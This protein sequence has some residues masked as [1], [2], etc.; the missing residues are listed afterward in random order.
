MCPARE[1]DGDARDA[2]DPGREPA[3]RDV[4]ADAGGTTGGFSRRDFEVIDTRRVERADLVRDVLRR[5]RDA[6]RAGADE[7]GEVRDAGVESSGG[8]ARGDAVTSAAGGAAAG[9]DDTIALARDAKGRVEA[10]SAVVASQPERDSAGDAP[11][12]PA[13]RRGAV[14]VTLTDAVPT[15][16]DTVRLSRD[17][18]MRNRSDRLEPGAPRTRLQQTPPAAAG[19]PGAPSSGGPGPHRRRPPRPNATPSD[20][21]GAALAMLRGWRAEAESRAATVAEAQLKARTERGRDRLDPTSELRRAVEGEGGREFLRDLLDNVIRPDDRIVA[22]NGLGDLA[23]RIPTTISVQARRAFRVGVFAGPGVPWLAVPALRRTARAFFGA[24]VVSDSSEERGGSA[25][26]AHE[27][28][29]TPRATP[30]GDPIVGRARAAE[31]LRRLGELV[32]DPAFPE[33]EFTM[34]DLEPNPNLWNLDGEVER[35]ATALAPLCAAALGSPSTKVGPTRLMLRATSSRDLELTVRVFTR[36]LD[37]PALRDLHAGIA[38]PAQF[39]ET[40]SLL[41]RVAGLA[42]IR[43]EDGG[44]PVTVAITRAGDIQLERVDAVMNGWRLATFA[45]ARDVDA[46]VIRLL[47]QALHADNAEAVRVELDGDVLRDVAMAI[48]LAEARGM[49]PVRVVVPVGRGD[50]AVARLR[51]AGAEVIQRLP[52][53]PDESMRAAV[54]YLLRRVDQEADAVA[55]QELSEATLAGRDALHPEDERLL[56]AVSRMFQLPGGANRQQER[57]HADDA[58]TVTASIGLELFPEGVLGD[59]LGVDNAE[60]QAIPAGRAAVAPQDARAAMRARIES[61]GGTDDIAD[62]GTAGDDI[63]NDGTAGDD[64]VGDDTVGDDTVGDDIG[65]DEPAPSAPPNRPPV[66][67]SVIPELELELELEADVV[68]PPGANERQKRAA[69]SATEQFGPLSTANPADT[70]PSARLTEIVLGLRRGRYLRNTFRNAPDTDPSIPVN[71]EWAARIQRRVVRGQLG[72]AEA[73]EARITGPEQV[74][75]LLQRAV[76][77]APGWNTRPGWERAAHLERAAKAVEA[78]RARLVEVAVSEFGVPLVDADA[79]V[80][81]TVDVANHAA[82]LARQLD[83]MQGAAFHP[84]GVTVVLPPSSPPVTGS[85]GGALTALAAG[86]AVILKASPKTRRTAGVLAGVLWAAELPRDL[87][88]LAVID[89]ARL[90]EEQ[91]AR[92]LVTDDRVGRVLLTGTLESARTMLGWRPDLPLIAGTSGKNSI[93]VT[94]AADLDQAAVDVARSA[95]AST[96]QR[97]GHAGNVILVGSVTRSRRFLQQLADAV[98]SIPVGYPSD[99]GAVAGPLVHPADAQLR[100]ALTHLGEG[101][102]W[103]VEP[104]QLDDTGRLWTPGIRLGVQPG[105]YAH[106]TE[107][108]GPVLGVMHARTFGEA[109]AMQNATQYGL[110]A[111]LQSH[112]RAEIGR[113]L[114]EVQAGNLYVNR[115]TLGATVQRQPL[116]G[117][118]RSA[119]GTLQKSGGPNAIMPLGEWRI[120]PGQPSPTLHLRGMDPKAVRLIEAAQPALDYEAFDRVRRTAL[121]TQ[122]A[123]NEE[124]GEVSDVTS[125]TFERNLFRYLPAAVTVRLAEGAP[126]DELVR[127]LVV[128]RIVRA[129]PDVSTAQRLPDAVVA[130]LDD[131]QFPVRVESDAAFLERLRMKQLDSL[132]IRLIGGSRREVALALGGD[133]D[134]AV[135]SDPVT[136]AG[137]V[138]AL[139]FLREQ[140]ISITAHRNGRP[141]PRVTSL[142]AHEKLLDPD[143]PFGDLA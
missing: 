58:A 134:V 67:E 20:A 60:T 127:A 139:P 49:P 110:A 72:E 15:F 75:A 44:A 9:D 59:E 83:R 61:R 18:F 42:H 46:S 125:L 118:R 92:T 30:L 41:R 113:W 96:G 115:D 81:R 86:S 98:T 33:V 57:V 142:F 34:S 64:T 39:P 52:I 23:D 93:I 108:F 137:R 62:D 105:S 124:F 29:A 94:P 48:A 80:S 102:R 101:E 13:P 3:R 104:R 126:F 131:L 50:E 73:A 88:Q 76:E 140:S 2:A 28:G 71:R 82:Y 66:T 112:D 117:W 85:A 132:R 6:V 26:H 84:V 47:E 22:G 135:W 24:E 35:I 77:A 143:K 11:D 91:L 122:I 89:E 79:D 4:P 32:D 109:I 70:G 56:D 136:F 40:T 8:D 116:G 114:Q 111:G 106:V 5:R 107:F 36:L 78:N 53:V 87:V 21:S 27:A 38:L 45:E 51:A 68:V 103:L 65:A 100:F 14:R 10:A 12:E 128:A 90:A 123:W 141:D 7:S 120:D 25:A 54:P 31:R 16:D 17:P 43:R 63:A 97:T 55:R 133:P 99:A 37:E 95:F 1:N 129:V 130:V 138:E 19:A 119:V 69:P 74:E 121:S